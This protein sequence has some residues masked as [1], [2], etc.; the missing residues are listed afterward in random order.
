[1]VDL[2]PYSIVED[3]AFRNLIQSACPFYT[4][5]SRKYYTELVNKEYERIRTLLFN[6]LRSIQYLALTSDAWSSRVADSYTTITCHFIQDGKLR[7]YVLETKS[8]GK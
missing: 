3:T 2:Q 5:H 6:E 7:D 1:M 8:F 4:L